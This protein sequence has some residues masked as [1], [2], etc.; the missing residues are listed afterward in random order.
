[1]PE[2]TIAAVQNLVKGTE[3]TAAAV[4]KLKSMKGVTDYRVEINRLANEAELLERKT[5]ARHVD[6]A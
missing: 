1:M 6:G 5:G 3:I 2:E 4:T